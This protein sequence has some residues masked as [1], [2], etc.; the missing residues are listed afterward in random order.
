MEVL[1]LFLTTCGYW[2]LMLNKKRDETK[3][4]Q[5]AGSGRPGGTCGAAGGIWGLRI[6]RNLREILSSSKDSPR[7]HKEFLRN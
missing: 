2:F 6:M 5:R 7:K 3:K 4:A 1:N